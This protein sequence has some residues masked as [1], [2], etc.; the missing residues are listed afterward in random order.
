MTEWNASFQSSLDLT[1]VKVDYRLLAGY[2]DLGEFIF[3]ESENYAY[4]NERKIRGSAC[5]ATGGFLARTGDSEFGLT[6]G[7][8][9]I[10]I[11]ED[12]ESV[13]PIFSGSAGWRTP[14]GKISGWVRL[15]GE[16]AGFDM[17]YAF[18]G[19]FDRTGFEIRA[20]FEQNENSVIGAGITL[21]NFKRD[22]E[23]GA[24]FRY[25]LVFPVYQFLCL[26]AEKTL[27]PVKLTL[28]FAPSFVEN[29]LIS[30]GIT[31]YFSETG[32]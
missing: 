25:G 3:T 16:D 5:H 13:L 29:S 27:G 8:R 9:K 31:V 12:D 17:E 30:A 14:I 15:E 26:R 18:E 23:V 4:R 6:G 7:F 2:T 21:M 28:G 24:L 10:R 32:P 22:L 1:I 20:V 19:F 11:G